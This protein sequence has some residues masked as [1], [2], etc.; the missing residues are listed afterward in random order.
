MSDLHAVFL[1][2]LQFAF[3]VGFHIIFPA[4]SIGLSSYLAM[5]EGLWL[6]TGRQVFLDLFHYWIKIFAIGFAMGVVSGIVMSYQFG[7]NWGSFSDKAGPVIGPLLGYEVLTAFFLESGFLGVMLFGMNRVGRGLHF[8][9]TCLVAIGTLISAFWILAVNSWMQTPAGF[10]MTADG[11]FLPADWLAIIFSPSFPY[12]LVHMVLATYLSV[13]FLVGAVGAWHVL[14]DRTNEGARVMMSMALWMALVVAPIQ[15]LAGD[16]HGENTL[17]HQPVKV[18]AME[19]DWVDPAP[20]AGE[21]LVLFAWPDERAAANRAEIAI[22]HLGSLI[23]THSWDGVI[24]GLRD[25][26]PA[27]RPPVAVVFYAFRI[28]VALGF[29]MAAIGL[30]GAFL[31]W[32]GRLYDTRPLLWLMVAMAPSGFVSVLAGWTVTEVGRQP[33]TVYGLLRTVDS[34]SPI[35][36]PGVATS[37]IAFVI[38]Y[39]LVYGAGI[40]FLLRQMARP[41]LPGEGGAPKA[42]SRAAGL[43][44]GPAGAIEDIPPTAAE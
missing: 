6:R 29:L 1:A 44:P 17:A 11:R 25:F 35:A 9:A 28:M 26:A 16:A 19:G 38:V 12:R 37:L 5:L 33:Y 40:T 24:K 22:P 30:L 23:L 7:T 15:I 10:T 14:R 20:G 32:R 36:A 4:F 2:R 41:P 39:F 3:V 27:D 42:P 13:A 34:A 18:A 43:M 21:P 8:L 31:R